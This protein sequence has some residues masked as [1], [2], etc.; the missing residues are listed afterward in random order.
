MIDWLFA[1]LVIV[2][3]VT[4][5]AHYLNGGIRFQSPVQRVTPQ[6][7]AH[8]SVIL[9]VM[10]LVK[11]G[12]Y[13]FAR[14]ELDFSE[15]RGRRRRGL[16]RRERAAA[17]AE[18]ADL[19]LGR[20]GAAVHLEHLAPRLGAARSSRSACGAS[21]RSSSARSTRPR[22]RTSRSSRTSSR[23]SDRTSRATSPRRVPRSTSTRSTSSSFRSRRSRRRPVG[24]RRRTADDRQRAPVGPGRHPVAPTRRSRRSQTYYQVNDVDIDRYTV[25]GQTT[26][27][28][29][30]ARELNSS[31]LPSQSWVNEHLVYTHGYG[32]IAS[33]TNQADIERRPDLLPAATSRRSEQGHHAEQQGRADLL[34]RGPRAA[35]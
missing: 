28:P 35:T 19:H 20:R 17:R 21:S 11:T 3:L 25:D 9:A 26:Q 1:G 31:A 18:P 27:V 33:P 30:S 13:F 14:Y 10:A 5:V 24:R 32:V 6:V 8:L 22:S 12:E 7:K 34:R 2:L 15:P 29:I 23:T 4:A 16:H